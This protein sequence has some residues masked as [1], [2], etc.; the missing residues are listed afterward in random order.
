MNIYPKC[1]RSLIEFYN[2]NPK[3]YNKII[4]NI[5]P[6]DVTLRDGLQGLSVAEQS[7]F[8]TNFKKEIYNLLIQIHNPKNIEI[9]SCINKNILPIFNDTK[10]LFKYAEE[11]NKSLD[12]KIN[13][14]ILVPNEEQLK[15]ALK[16][17]V[18]NFSFIT[19]VSNSFQIK[20]T[21]MSLNDNYKNLTNMM[22]YLEDY[23]DIIINQ[24]TGDIYKDFSTYKVKLYVSCINECP[25]EGKIPINQIV[26]ELVNLNKLNFDTIC[27]SDTCGT[28][29]SKDFIDIIDKSKKNV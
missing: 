16:F 26:S 11:N 18:K 9:G 13:N 5:K 25:I 1:A 12:N 14:Y 6:F 20:N 7:T 8:T 22:Y 23:L 10:D 28:L 3:L 17:G 27:L 2:V 21:K 4:K 24:E 19:S 15:N 29:N